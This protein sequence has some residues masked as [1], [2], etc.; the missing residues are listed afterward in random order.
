MQFNTIKDPEDFENLSEEWNHLLTYCSASH[1]PFLRHEYLSTWW[2]TLG[3][4]EWDQGE[5]HVVTGRGQRDELLGVAPLFISSNREGIP[6]LLLLGCVEISD[7]LDMIVHEDQTPTFATGLLDYLAKESA[8][9]WQIMDLYNIL[10]DSPSIPALQEA[11]Q[12]RGWGFEQERLQHC[13]Y[14]PLPGD[15]DEYLAGIHK[16][17]RHE[18]RRKMRRADEFGIPVSWYIAEDESR[19]D[20]EIEDFFALMAQDPEKDQFLTELMRKQLRESIHAAFQA[21]WL[22]LSFLV[23]GDEKTAGYLNFD[24]ADH[25]WVYNSG[26]NFTYRELSPGWVLLGH[27]LKWANEKERKYFDFMRGDERYKYRFGAVDRFVMRVTL[28]RDQS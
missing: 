26:I 19:L 1:V 24:Y 25:I 12:S 23:A 17:Q 22:Q 8:P 28:S 5:L 7:Y 9:D 11:A 14:V 18:I 2:K 27:L 21:G 10:E 15:W 4:G 16:K 3:G 20:L 13:P 6:A